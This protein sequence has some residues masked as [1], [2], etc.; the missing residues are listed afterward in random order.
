VIERRDLHEIRSR[1]PDQEHRYL[2]GF[3]VSRMEK[4]RLQTCEGMQG[5][6]PPKV[7]PV[8]SDLLQPLSYGMTLAPSAAVP[9]TSARAH[10]DDLVDQ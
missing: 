7:R 4:T 1:T 8:L 9:K 10:L 5:S 3:H 6:R 2:A